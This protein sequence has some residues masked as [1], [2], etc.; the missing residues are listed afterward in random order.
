MDRE[1][2]NE[3]FQG[4]VARAFAEAVQARRVRDE[5]SGEPSSP[6]TS[7]VGLES[8]GGPQE[9]APTQTFRCKTCGAETTLARDNDGWVFVNADGF[10]CD[11]YERRVVIEVDGPEW[12]LSTADLLRHIISERGRFARALM[13][14]DAPSKRF[15]YIETLDRDGWVIKT[16]LKQARKAGGTRLYEIERPG[17]PVETE[18]FKPH[19]VDRR[20]SVGRVT[21]PIDKL[22]GTGSD[23]TIPGGYIKD[24]PVFDRE[25]DRDFF[26]NRRR[27][28]KGGGD[29]EGDGGGGGG[30]STAIKAK[31]RYTDRRR[32]RPLG[33]TSTA[34]IRVEIRDGKVLRVHSLD[35]PADPLKEFPQALEHLLK[36]KDRERLAAFRTSSDEELVKLWGITPQ[37]VRQRR[38]RLRLKL[39]KVSQTE[40][41]GE[42]PEERKMQTTDAPTMVERVAQLE[43]DW[44]A[45]KSQ[46]AEHARQLGITHDVDAVREAVDVFLESAL[47][48]REDRINARP[49]VDLAR[50]SAPPAIPN[51]RM[52]WASGGL[53]TCEDDSRQ[54][55]N[56]DSEITR[57]NRERRRTG[58]ERRD[59][60][61]TNV[62]VSVVRASLVRSP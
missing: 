34:P 13:E 54:A 42:G 5:V 46:L 11:H 31:L 43:T 32:G 62:K 30:F 33:R 17:Q 18:P 22:A 45:M 36:P 61:G 44:A 49:P 55:M 53:E 3:D 50:Q 25:S 60:R 2:D 10:A 15:E 40:I 21:D 9:A 14:G 38:S 26:S 27:R 28:N 1:T 59:E 57:G 12:A 7:R 24:I 6:P 35:A 58:D 39:R 23:W 29:H 51:C 56:A 48:T 8:G 16:T 41:K 37:N 19:A 47:Y 4:P 52:R 20:S